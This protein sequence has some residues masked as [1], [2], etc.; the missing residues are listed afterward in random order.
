VHGGKIWCENRDGGGAS[1][2]FF[3][4]R[5]TEVPAME[6]PEAVADA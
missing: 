3:L 6:L 5:E 1:F 2:C 4:P